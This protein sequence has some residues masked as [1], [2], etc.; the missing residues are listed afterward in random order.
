MFK[1]LLQTALLS[2]VITMPLSVAQAADHALV[3]LASPHSVAKTVDNLASAV[4]KAGAKVFARVN[5]GKGGASVGMDIPDNELL[6]FGNPK[7]G[8]PILRDAAAAGLDLPI[9]VVVVETEKG[10]M[11]IYRKPAALAKMHGLPMDHP[12]I[13]KMTGALKKL[14][15]KAAQ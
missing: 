8:T 12:S 9:R 10:T 4:E 11:I 14:T 3:K 1:P 7:L 6:I 13:M 15:T 2:A 5:H